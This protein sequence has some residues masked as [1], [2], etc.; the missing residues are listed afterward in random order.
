LS[1]KSI[2]QVKLNLDKSY[3]EMHQVVSKDKVL[4]K[5]TVSSTKY[6]S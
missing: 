2:L 3:S 6:D 5:Q 1:L 4:L